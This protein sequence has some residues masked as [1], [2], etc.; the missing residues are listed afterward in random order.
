MRPTSEDKVSELTLRIED[1]KAPGLK[2][3]TSSSLSP[4]KLLPRQG[5]PDV[6][7]FLKARANPASRTSVD[8]E[9]IELCLI[10]KMNSV[11]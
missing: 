4:C 9:I 7:G 11:D 8:Y 1:P 2:L 6:L 5:K 10:P 3:N